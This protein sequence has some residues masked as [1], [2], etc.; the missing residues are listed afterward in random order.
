MHFVHLFSQFCIC[1]KGIL[2][3]D[4]FVVRCQIH[5]RKRTPSC[6]DLSQLKSEILNH[7]PGEIEN[8]QV[9]LQFINRFIV[10][11]GYEHHP[12]R[13]KFQFRKTLCF[14]FFRGEVFLFAFGE[15]RAE[16]LSLLGNISLFQQSQ[17]VFRNGADVAFGI[18]LHQFVQRLFKF[19]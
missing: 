6:I 13:R 17:N 8:G 1:G 12:V 18:I 4:T 2:V 7:K 14:L 10:S 16:C 11:I 15:Q 19:F 9:V 3:P 5:H